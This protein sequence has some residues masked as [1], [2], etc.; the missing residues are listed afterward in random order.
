MKNKQRVLLAISSVL[1]LLLLFQIAGCERADIAEAE[2]AM[3]EGNYAEA[4]WVWRR[5]ADE[6][7]PI[8][9]YNL[10]WMY[11]NGF[12]LVVDDRKAADWWQN[13]AESGLEDAEEALGMLYYYGGQGV[14]R[15]LEKSAE[16]LIPGVVR[17][18]EEAALL[19][20]SFIGKLDPDIRKRFERLL[21]EKK[22]AAQ[23]QAEAEAEEV[24]DALGGEPLIVT[25]KLANLRSEPTTQ[26]SVV[27]TLERGAGLAEVERK[28]DW[29]KVNFAI[30]QAS[31]WIHVDLVKKTD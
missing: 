5:L 6:G 3:Q 27:I 24:A 18:D 29:V 23:E 4:Y 19:L 7:H 10:G 26:S 13:A 1:A 25:A 9:M 16:Y 28:G 15:D 20:E 14:K 21:E 2:S 11:H 8:A 22:E 12:G 30:D 31:A 17:G